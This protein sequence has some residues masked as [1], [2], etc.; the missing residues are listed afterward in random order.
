[1]VLRRRVRSFTY[2]VCTPQPTTSATLAIISLERY[3]ASRNYME[4]AAG[5][6]KSI[7]VR[8]GRPIEDVM[9]MPLLLD[10]FAH[11]REAYS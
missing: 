11:V 6:R 1:M 5:L 9:A 10:D 3:R 4:F 7:S 2:L 8:M